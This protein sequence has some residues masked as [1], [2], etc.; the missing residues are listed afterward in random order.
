MDVIRQVAEAKCQD[1][2]RW[3]PCCRCQTCDDTRLRWPGLSISRTFRKGFSGIDIV[4]I[5]DV[6]LEK[7]LLLLGHTVYLDR[8]YEDAGDWMVSRDMGIGWYSSSV[9]WLEAACAA[10]LATV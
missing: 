4:R 9:G 5:P 10:L 8:E 3:N 6:T 7:V 2:H 1:C